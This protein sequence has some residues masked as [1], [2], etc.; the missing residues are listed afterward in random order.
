V[1]ELS[2]ATVL[3]H[4]G[5]DL[6]RVSE[7]GWRKIR[8]PFTDNHK[9]GDRVPSASVNLAENAFACH[10]CSAKGD[11]ISLIKD[12]EGTDYQGALK[13]A[14][15]VLGQSV[16]GVRHPARRASPVERSEWRDTLFA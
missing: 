9:R 11:A 16:D 7:H 4:Y 14:E 2:I 1:A 13:F 8:C 3:E 15:E 12:Q 6:T 5:A 10:A